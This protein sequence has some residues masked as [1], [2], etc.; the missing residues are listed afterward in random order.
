MKKHLIAAAVATAIAAPAMAQ[1]TMS[2]AIGASNTETK[3]GTA[4]GV[5]QSQGQGQD[6]WKTTH[7]TLRGGVDLGGGLKAEF[8]L[9]GDLSGAGGKLGAADN[10]FNRISMVAISGPFGTISLGRQ[11]DSVKDIEGLGNAINLSDNLFN[12]TTV[13]DRIANAY[14]YATPTINGFKATATYSDSRTDATGDAGSSVS[15]TSIRHSSYAI[16]GAVAGINLAVGTGTETT[17]TVE[18]KTTRMGIS[19]PVMSGLSVG[20]NYTTN[21]VG[22]SELDQFMIQAKYTAGA[23]EVY[24][25]YGDNDATSTAET[26]LNARGSGNVFQA[27]AGYNLSKRTA[28]Y[29]GYSDFSADGTASA[30]RDQ[31]VTTIGVYHSF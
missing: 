29:A 25:T 14:K 10:I 21:E 17:D 6:H 5:N 22:T 1:V 3:T 27:I 31:R 24:A 23:W 9:A 20:A 4:Q 7:I 8:M 11:N 18:S 26:A 13:G 12:V 28:V 30:A 19:V 2:G 16:T 15:G